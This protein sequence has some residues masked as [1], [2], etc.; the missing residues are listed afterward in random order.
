MSQKRSHSGGLHFANLPQTQEDQYDKMFSKKSSTELPP[1][2]DII[3]DLQRPCG[4]KRKGDNKNCLFESV[5][6]KFNFFSTENKKDQLQKVAKW[7]IE[8]KM[9]IFQNKSCGECLIQTDE[10][11]KR[12]IVDEKID[13]N[14]K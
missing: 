3:C 9:S 14:G 5:L 10:I 12:C 6:C 1:M 13:K 7:L 8:N 2:N 11:F 4:C